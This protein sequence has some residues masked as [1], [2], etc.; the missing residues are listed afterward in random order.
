VTSFLGCFAATTILLTAM[1]MFFGGA[2]APLAP[3]QSY[4]CVS[5]ASW[6]FMQAGTSERI[7]QYLR[8]PEWLIK[9]LRPAVLRL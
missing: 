9:L 6:V 5:C 7:Q 3:A 1:E 8:L 4:I 2:D